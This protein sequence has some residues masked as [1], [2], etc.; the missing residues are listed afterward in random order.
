MRK[1]RFSIMVILVFTL[2]FYN[3]G[4]ASTISNDIVFVIDNSESMK[5]GDPHSLTKSAVTD[6]IN[7]LSDDTQI[8]VVIFD[9]RVNLAI[10]LTVVSEANKNIILASLDSIDYKGT[11]TNIPDALKQAV[12][13]VKDNGQKASIKSIVLITDGVVDTGDKSRDKTNMEELLKKLPN[14]AARFGIKIF[15]ISF[16]DA[17]DSELI[18]QLVQKTEGEYFNALTSEEIPE[19]FSRIYQHITGKEPG[20]TKLNPKSPKPPPVAFE[21]SAQKFPL[22]TPPKPVIE[23]SPIYM[24]EKPEP[25]PDTVKSVSEESK[26]ATSVKHVMKKPGGLKPV[27]NRTKMRRFPLP[28][29]IMVLIAVGFIVTVIFILSRFRRRK[30][31]TPVSTPRRRSSPPTTPAPVRSRPIPDKPQIK[32]SAEYM[33]EALLRDISGV[34]GEETYKLNETNTNIGRKEKINQIVIK[35]DTISRQHAVIEYKEYSFWVNDKESS[36][37]TFLNGEKIINEMQLNNGDTISVDVYDFEFVLPG[38]ESAKGD[39][40]KTIFRNSYDIEG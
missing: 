39:M 33:P 4:L 13:E 8:A 26:P 19:I 28:L 21:E 25:T 10:P 34:T 20:L 14:A 9:H 37:G 27:S 6:F 32:E 35:Q 17:A 18:Q 29:P 2:W 38:L 31:T 7:N 40:D 12:F 11:L 15:G 24:T 36:N 3:L 16:T 5:K 1:Y 30:A 23:Q 22:E